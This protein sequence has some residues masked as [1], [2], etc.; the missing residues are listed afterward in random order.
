MIK[1]LV[2]ENFPM[3]SIDLLRSKNYD[4]VSVLRSYSG[5]SDVEVIQLANQEQRLILTFDKDFG[6]LIFRD[7]LIPAKGVFY[8]R[9][10]EFYPSQPGEM[11]LELLMRDGFDPTGSIT[12][13]DKSFI[14][15]KK[16]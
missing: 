3:A 4:I 11:I 13:I 12:V 10:E 15:Q 9:L 8:F 7:G 14:R 2:D 16:F 1:L 5:I 6:F